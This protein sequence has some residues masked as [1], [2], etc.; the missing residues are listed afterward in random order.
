MFVSMGRFVISALMITAILTGV[1]EAVTVDPATTYQTIEGIGVFPVVPTLFQK[2]GL[3]YMDR[4]TSWEYDRMCTDLGISGVRFQLAT[5]GS[6]LA[7][8]KYDW[9]G[10]KG[11]IDFLKQCKARGVD[12]YIITILNP[13]GW[14]KTNGIPILGGYLLDAEY[15]GFAEYMAQM[16]KALKDSVGVEPYGLCVQNEPFFQEPYGSCQYSDENFS[17]LSTLAKQRLTAL[18][19]TTRLFAASDVCANYQ[20]WSTT[21]KNTAIYASATHI[22]CSDWNAVANY[23]KSNNKK[24]WETEWDIQPPGAPTTNYM[25][26]GG[27]LMSGLKAGFSWW[28]WF[29]YNNNMGAGAHG[30]DLVDTM[31]V[32]DKRYY[33]TKMFSRFIRRDAVRIGCTGGSANSAAFKNP[34]NTISVIF[35]NSGGATTES[36]TGSGLPAVW[37]VYR[38]SATENC[39]YIGQSGGTDIQVPGAS[40]VSVISDSKVPEI[41]PDPTPYHVAAP[42]PDMTVGQINARGDDMLRVWVNGAEVPLKE[43]TNYSVSIR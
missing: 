40:I 2:A 17:K 13:P 12:R 41:P 38:T 3:F 19:L 23:A 30:T 9:N 26:P 35:V 18:G 34:D 20:N 4:P 15:D 43:G 6:Y 31:W 21:I 11:E 22:A 42:T 10:I 39:V 28:T 27:S 25:T 8:G 14:A 24:A 32:P 29:T 36:I 1:P 37:H 7:R 16:C 33:A 5:E